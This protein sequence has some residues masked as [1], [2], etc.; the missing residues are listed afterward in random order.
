MNLLDLTTS[1]PAGGICQ[2]LVC[3]VG[4]I[5]IIPILV[6]R[7]HADGIAEAIVAIDAAGNMG[8]AG[9]GN[10]TRQVGLDVLNY[11]IVHAMADL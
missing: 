11:P 9:I 6:L 8:M 4:R 10:T 3:A 7:V 5:I 2:G 1:C